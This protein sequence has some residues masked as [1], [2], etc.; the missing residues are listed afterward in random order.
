MR[1]PGGR[2]DVH[3]AVVNQQGIVRADSLSI[4][5]DGRPVLSQAGGVVTLKATDSLALAAGSTTSASGSSGGTIELDGGAGSTHIVGDVQATGSGGAGGSVRVLG[6]RVALA[7]AASVDVSGRTGGGDVLVGGGERGQDPSV[8][9]ARTVD[10]GA[11]VTLRAD[12]VDSGDGGRL[13]LWSDQATRAYGSFSARGGSGGG[14][15]GLIETSGGWIDVR[16]A[17]IDAT[18]GNGLAGSWLLDPYNLLITDD[19]TTNGVQPAPFNGSADASA[20]GAT[21][22]TADIRNALNAGTSVVI[23]TGGSGNEAGNITVRDANL[24]VAPATAVGADAEAARDIRMLRTTISSSNAPLALTLQGGL[25]GQGAV[26]IGSTNAGSTMAIAT[27]GGNVTISGKGYDL[28]GAGAAA[29]VGFG[30]AMVNTQINAGAGT[31]TLNG[32]SRVVSNG[33]AGGVGVALSQLTANAIAIDGSAD[34]SVAG[35][36]AFGVGFTGARLTAGDITINGSA[37]AA[38]PVS[39]VTSWG[40]I[41]DTSLISATRSLT[42]DGTAGNF[43]VTILGDSVVQLTPPLTGSTGVLSIAGRGTSTA[44]QIPSIGTTL[45][46]GNN[47]ATTLRATNGA[48][49]AVSGSSAGAFPGFVSGGGV[50]VDSPSLG[51]VELRSN[52]FAGL[53]LGLIASGPVRVLADSVVMTG[54]MITS[55]APGNAIVFSGAS[56]PNA[57]SFVNDAGPA[58]L[59]TPNGRWLI[60]G[61]APAA[62]ITGGLPY[63]FRQYDARFGEANALTPAAGNGV[64]YALAPVISVTGSA[65]SKVYDGKTATGPLASAGLAFSGLVA[66]DSATLATGAGGQF[67]D[68]DAGLNKA[69]AL[70]GASVSVVGAD[71]KPVLGYRLTSSLRGDILRRGISFAPPTAANKIYDGTARCDRHARCVRWAGPRRDARHLEQRPLRQQGR[72]QRQA[73][74][75]DAGR[76]RRQHRQGRQLPG[77]DRIDDAGRHHAGAAGLCRESGRC[78][79]RLGFPAAQRQGRRLRRRRVAGQCDDRHAGVHHAG[80]AGLAARPVSDRGW[81]P[82]GDQLPLH[83]GARQCDGADADRAAAADDQRRGC[84]QESRSRRR[85]PR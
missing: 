43:G 28:A 73:G 50:V 36:N 51:G 42:L 68:P 13:V 70:A 7:D 29:Y 37:N 18:A 15:G 83:A 82:R 52:N 5:A 60:F 47:L 17:K 56:G 40:S 24:A 67:A 11:G 33:S 45:S 81:R 23:T 71:G 10:V 12:A 3:A 8:A 59:L 85:W 2:I 14:N 44:A 22:A 1:S 25:S 66:G 84:E 75:G 77:A 6:A 41:V 32:S 55:L 39:P 34:S 27:R 53:D 26:G 46:G 38:Q 30:V 57:V 72:R 20:T 21:I 78:G 54:G 69:V 48:R 58:S 65:V 19:A 79:R 16:P 64:L 80:D 76:D 4:G 49:I 35:D 61:Q 74:H 63:D 62:I 31:L 9:N